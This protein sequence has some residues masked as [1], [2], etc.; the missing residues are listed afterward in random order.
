MPPQSWVSAKGVVVHR[1]ASF[2]AVWK[3]KG[4]R[5]PIPTCNLLHD[6]DPS[7]TSFRYPDPSLKQTLNIDIHKLQD[8]LSAGI[9]W[10]WAVYSHTDEMLSSAPSASDY[11]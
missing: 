1:G 4:S 5:C 7:G 6:T 9:D 8:D 3:T 2:S 10:L 11:E